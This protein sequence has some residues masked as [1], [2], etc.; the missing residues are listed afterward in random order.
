MSKPAAVRQLDAQQSAEGSARRPVND[1][2]A[3]QPALR[4]LQFEAE[5]RRERNESDLQ[6]VVTNGVPRLI[7][8]QTVML[9]RLRSATRAWKLCQISGVVGFD[10]DTEGVRGLQK[11]LNAKHKCEGLSE[12]HTWTTFHPP[13]FS[14][15]AASD[16]KAMPTAAACP[17]PS[18]FAAAYAVW[19]P[20]ADRKGRVEAGLLVLSPHAPTAG[21]TTLL[22]R[23][24]E[25]AAHAW[26]ALP[27]DRH[28]GLRGF[29]SPRRTLLLIGL[30]AAIGAI[31]VRLSVMAPVEVVAQ[32]PRIITAPI[33][34]VIKTVVVSP[35]EPV[36]E[37][38]VLVQFEDV[39]ARNESV[40]TL[41]RVAVAQAHYE[42]LM[43]QAFT[44]A[45]ATHELASARAEYEL[46]FVNHEYAQEVL[47]RT[48]ISASSSGV[49]VYADR[50]DWQGR[51]VQVGEEIMQVADPARVAYKVELSVGNKIPLTPGSEAA[52]YLDDAP[53]G[54]FGGV[55]KTINY[56]PKYS[57]GNQASYTVMVEA[58]GGDTPRIG[59]KGTARLYGETRPLAVQLL[60]RPLAALRLAVGL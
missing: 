30:V 18:E 1:D 50:R 17:F 60:R 41:Q 14:P 33:Q 58:A 49:A 23:I 11:W 46:A 43:A 36:Q 2:A 27:T 39:Q 38:D 22:S 6:F 31:P 21:E 47:R 19:Q 15:E 3:T 55:I 24:A 25:T 45:A 13:K 26:N 53:L 40:L 52:I 56:S 10:E 16:R 42:K 37:G 59:S 28:F 54:G 29:F 8:C 44:D 51:A 12:P 9:F 34:G 35:N 48:R 57:G 32:A 7:R 5:L 4:L 20:L